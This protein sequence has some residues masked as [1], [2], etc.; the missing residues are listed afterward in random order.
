VNAR[1]VERHGKFG[2]CRRRRNK[3][4]PRAVWFGATGSARF[5]R[6]YPKPEIQGFRIE[7]QANRD[8]LDR[9]GI[10][11]PADYARIPEILIRQMGFYRMNWT[12]LSRFMRRHLRQPDAILRM[13]RRRSGILIELL[14]FLRSISIA[15]PDRF[16]LPMAINGRISE[17]LRQWAE[18]WN[19]DAEKTPTR[20]V[21]MTKIMRRNV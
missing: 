4:F 11:T 14:T 13:A 9:Y 7:H 19:R 16:L 12:E 18:Q 6:G 21:V 17:A 1:F 15:N 2:K 10:K 3:R 8:F 20:K 5:F